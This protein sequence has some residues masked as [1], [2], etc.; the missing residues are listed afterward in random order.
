ME[1]KFEREIEDILSRLDKFPSRGP[2]HRARRAFG[3]AAGSLQQSI[4][5][6][7]ARL[8]LTRVMVTAIILIFVGYFFRAALPSLWSYVVAAGL[9]LFFASFLISF[10]GRQH[11]G[12]RGQVYWRGRPASAYSPSGPS[13]TERLR[14][15]W[16]RHQRRRF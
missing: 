9:I 13:L 14:D 3:T 2:T 16:R 6:R 11:A 15:W 7:L 4:A 5:T 1:D 10:L 12:S 8:T